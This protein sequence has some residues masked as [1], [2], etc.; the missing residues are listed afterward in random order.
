MARVLSISDRFK[1]LA[2]DNFRCVYCGATPQ[3]TQLHIDHVIP[4]SKGGSN[5]PSNLVTACFNCNVGKNDTSLS[6]IMGRTEYKN[7]F[8]TVTT[9]G[10]EGKNGYWIERERLNEI[11][12]Y[13]GPWCS[14]WI[15]H[16]SHK[17]YDFELFIDAFY[18]AFLISGTWMR[19]DW[20][21]SV[22][23]GRKSVKR[24]KLWEIEFHRRLEHKYG[25]IPLVINAADFGLMDGWNSNDMVSK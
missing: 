17:N 12:D 6:E 23:R 2:R 25:E 19:F 24:S 4:K 22:E 1:I 3:R 13:V 18:Q 16:F 14:D 9:D 5:D 8:W 21:R 7:E 11:A 15:V 10:M 20:E